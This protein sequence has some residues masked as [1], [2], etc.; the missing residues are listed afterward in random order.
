[1]VKLNRGGGV[2]IEKKKQLTE[3]KIETKYN[4]LRRKKL[5]SKFLILKKIRMLRS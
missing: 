2:K 1:M 5:T 3:V 4:K